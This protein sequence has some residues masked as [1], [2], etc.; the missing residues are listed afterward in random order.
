MIL[1]KGHRVASNACSPTE[2]FKLLSP[3]IDET[4]HQELSG[5]ENSLLAPGSQLFTKG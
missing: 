5:L 2:G 1:C 4:L 3:I